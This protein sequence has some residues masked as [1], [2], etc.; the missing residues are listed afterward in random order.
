MYTFLKLSLTL[1][2]VPS[3]CPFIA[4]L[5]I[6]AA[7]AAVISSAT[8]NAFHTPAGPKP[9]SLESIHAAGIM[10]T[11]YLSRDMSRDGVP[12]PNPSSAPDEVTDTADTTNPAHIMRSAVPPAFIVDTFSV[13]IPISLFRDKQAHNCSSQHDS[14][15]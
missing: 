2:Q 10:T 4:P 1:F 3:R 7:H 12:F 5:Y 15:I 13:N 14:N 8:Q 11:T 6:N 9:Q